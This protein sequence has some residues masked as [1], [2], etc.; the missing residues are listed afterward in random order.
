DPRAGRRAGSRDHVGDAR[1][2]LRQDRLR[3]GVRA[4]SWR[5]AL[6]A[7]DHRTT[8]TG[9]AENESWFARQRRK[10]RW[11]DHLVRAYDAF[12]ERNGNHYAAAIT[13]FSVLSLFPLLMVAF[14]IVGFILAGN[15]TQL[16]NL[17]QA[18]TEAVP[19]GLGPLIND[20]VDTAIA[21]RSTV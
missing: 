1:P 10:Y 21:E 19:E 11:L 9:V 14:A 3:A 6:R 2:G 18:I 4:L 16:A 15:P 12:T 7:D 20:V 5:S 17:Q 13:Y 8:V